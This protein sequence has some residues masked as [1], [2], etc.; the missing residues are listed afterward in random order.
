MEERYFDSSSNDISE[1]GF[2]EEQPSG[3]QPSKKS[4]SPSTLLLA[5]IGAALVVVVMVTVW[6]WER[7][8]TQPP[9]KPL[10][11]TLPSAQ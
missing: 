9:A 3:T 4:L 8:Q 10:R 5:A 2:Q 6:F 1:E 11:D 7:P